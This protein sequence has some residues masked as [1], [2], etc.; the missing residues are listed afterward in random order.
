MKIWKWEINIRK[1]AIF[2]VTFAFTFTLISVI[3]INRAFNLS[4]HAI[5]EIKISYADKMVY[6]KDKEIIDQ[7]MDGFKG[8]IIIPDSIFPREDRESDFMFVFYGKDN[9]VKWFIYDHQNRQLHPSGRPMNTSLYDA[10]D[11][12][13]EKTCK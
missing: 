4:N 12:F 7:L 3:D 9:F 2:T 11:A 10:L 13:I 6:V 8:N 5:E 1:I